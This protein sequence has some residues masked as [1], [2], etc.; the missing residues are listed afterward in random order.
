MGFWFQELKGFRCQ[1]S[2]VRNDADQ[3]G[4]PPCRPYS[5]LGYDLKPAGTEA[6]PTFSDIPMFSLKPDTRH[7]KPYFKVISHLKADK[8]LRSFDDFQPPKKGRAHWAVCSGATKVVISPSM[9]S[10]PV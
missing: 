9:T 4:R 10:N 1:V 2:G 8:S 7:L 3:Q 6:H 5:V